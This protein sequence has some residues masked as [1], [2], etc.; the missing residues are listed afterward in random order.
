VSSPSDDADR[1]QAATVLLKRRS[2]QRLWE[3]SAAVVRR[4]GRLA[5]DAVATGDPSRYSTVDPN[6][7]LPPA[8]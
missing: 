6:G 5:L 1:D 3:K 7:E 4:R 2:Q 8:A